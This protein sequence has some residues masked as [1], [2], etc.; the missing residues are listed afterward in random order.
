MLFPNLAVVIL[1]AVIG[2]D[3]LADHFDQLGSLIRPV[4]SGGD[5]DRDLV[6]RN[7]GGFE[8]SQHRRQDELI[9]HRP[10]DVADKDAGVFAAAGDFSEWPGTDRVPQGG[11]KAAAG[12]GNGSASRMASGPTTRS[13]GS[14]TFRPVRP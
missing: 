6:S 2:R 14:V 9:R 11:V 7:A 8:R 1:D 10:G 3:L 5:E 13:A 4:Q 12:S